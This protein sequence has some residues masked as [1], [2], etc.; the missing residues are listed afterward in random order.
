MEIKELLLAL[1]DEGLTDE[2]IVKVLDQKLADGEITQEDYDW[3]INELKKQ[4]DET[5]RKEAFKLLGVK[6]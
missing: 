2:E 1:K 3:A 5:E 4:L 6:E